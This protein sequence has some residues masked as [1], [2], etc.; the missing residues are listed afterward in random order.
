[1]ILHCREALEVLLLLGFEKQHLFLLVF[2][3]LNSSTVLT[4]VEA[5]F[6]IPILLV[7]VLCIESARSN[8]RIFKGI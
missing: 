5:C 8:E 4:S 3:I 2:L 1:M 7:T 6:D